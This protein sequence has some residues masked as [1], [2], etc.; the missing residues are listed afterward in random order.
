MLVGY[1]FA[2]IDCR[3]ARSRRLGERRQGLVAQQSAACRP[4]YRLQ[5]TGQYEFMAEMEARHA[6]R[7]PLT[8]VLVVALLYLSMRG[9]P[10]TLLVLL[11][12]RLRSPAASGCSRRFTTTSRPPSGWDSSPSAVWR[13]RPA[14]CGRLPGSGVS[15]VSTREPHSLARGRGRRRH[16]R[17]FGTRP[18]AGDDRRDDRVGPSPPALGVGHRCGCL[19]AH[20]RP[21]RRWLMVLHVPDAAGPASRVRDLAQR[22]VSREDR[23]AGR[24]MPSEPPGADQ[25][26]QRCFPSGLSRYTSWHAAHA[27]ATVPLTSTIAS[28]FLDCAAL[29]AARPASARPCAAFR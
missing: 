15:A 28:R 9:W 4:G 5:W 21:G 25:G 13:P 6:H 8:L 27:S 17:R 29:Y 22:S 12:C 24:L 1:V 14:S 7:L 18:P 26:M 3:S 19:C 2:D 10:Q 20:G 16:R 23:R 11:S